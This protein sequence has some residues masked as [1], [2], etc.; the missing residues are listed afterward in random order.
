VFFY[1]L[2]LVPTIW[3]LELTDLE[4]RIVEKE[5]ETATNSTPAV[6]ET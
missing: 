6:R 3:L 5:R 2:C 4:L 1:L